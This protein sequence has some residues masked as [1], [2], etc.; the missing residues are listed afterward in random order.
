M[1]RFFDESQDLGVDRAQVEYLAHDNLI[2]LPDGEHVEAIKDLGNPAHGG[3]LGWFAL[4]TE[5]SLFVFCQGLP[6][7]AFGQSID[8][9]GAGSGYDAQVIQAL[10]FISLSAFHPQAYTI[11]HKSGRLGVQN[12]GYNSAASQNI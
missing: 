11:I 8:E 6:Y 4:L 3:Y 10:C 1:D 2:V 12:V 7:M 9:Q 5:N